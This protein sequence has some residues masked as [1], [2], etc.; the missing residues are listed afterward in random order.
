MIQIIFVFAGECLFVTSPTLHADQKTVFELW[1]KQSSMSVE[2]IAIELLTE[3]MANAIKT[4]QYGAANSFLVLMGNSH[5]NGNI[6]V[7]ID[8]LLGKNEEGFIN[9]EFANLSKVD[10]KKI[11]F[12]NGA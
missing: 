3:N 2:E 11:I 7:K 8:T 12:K 5:V 10:M 1:R 9:D 6:D 4:T